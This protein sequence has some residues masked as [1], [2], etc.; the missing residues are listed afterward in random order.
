MNKTILILGIIFMLVGISLNPTIAVFN[1]N[2]D[3]TPPVTTHS[4]DP[5]EP[6]G[7]NGWY[8]SDIDV[9]LTATDNMSGVMKIQYRIDDGP[10]WTIP[11]DYGTFVLDID[12]DD[13][14]VEYWAV[15]NACNEETHHTFIIDVDRT[16]PV[17]DLQYEFQKPPNGGFLIFNATAT[18][19]TSKMNRVRFLLNDVEQDVIYGLGPI[20]S[21]KWAYHPMITIIIK[22]EAY[23]N[24]GNIAYKEIKN[25]KI[26]NIDQS[27]KSTIGA[28]KDNISVDPSNRGTTLYI[29]GSGPGNFSKIQDAIDNASDGDTVFVYDDSSPYVEWHID[30]DKSINLVGENK[31]TTIVDGNGTTIFRIVAD[32]VHI[33]GF[34]IQNS[35]ARGIRVYSDFNNISENIFC[36]V[37]K[38]VELTNCNNNK[39]YRNTIRVKGSLPSGIK[40]TSSDNNIFSENNLQGWHKKGIDLMEGSKNNI[41]SGNILN[42]SYDRGISLVQNSVN[43]TVTKNFVIRAGGGIYCHNDDVDNSIFTKNEVS[44]CSYGM[45]INVQ[46]S[47]IKDNIIVGS[48]KYG[49]YLYGDNNF[50]SGNII[51]DSKEGTFKISGGDFNKITNN[52][53]INNTNWDPLNLLGGSRNIIEKNN[54]IGNLGDAYFENSWGNRW[55]KNYWD[56]CNNRMAYFIYGIWE[57]YDPFD[58]DPY[59]GPIYTIRYYNADFRPARKPYEIPDTSMFE[60]CD[61]E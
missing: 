45:D 44:Y 59:A 48:S 8:V 60:G 58:M 17:V 13:I 42:G 11:G 2:D 20:Y 14:S 37:N 26:I 61:I 25:P 46:S 31:E 1:S 38:G 27:T 19:E 30:I 53:F 43:N 41:I 24:A 39:I 12:K 16:D 7:E 54:F 51:K 22:A 3:T 57:I 56:K 50:V 10:I 40:L 35:D 4:L 28:K 34:Y 49:M 55:S 47:Y 18:D 23:D 52:A 36:D 6:D 15:D 5:P 32:N 9:T 29:G 21:W 33:T